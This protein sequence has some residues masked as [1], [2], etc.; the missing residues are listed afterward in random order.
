MIPILMYHAVSDDLTAS[1]R[2]YSSPVAEF[3]DQ[4]AYLDEHGY[5]SLTLADLC[6]RWSSGEAVPEK[7]VVITFDDGYECVHRTALPIL[8]RHGFVATTFVVSQY[9]GRIADFDLDRGAKARQ[10]LSIAQLRELLSAG[11]EIG[12]HSATHPTLTELARPDANAQVRDSRRQLEDLLGAPVTS[13]AYPKGRYNEAI[14]Q[15]VV[16]S[17][18]SAA[19]SCT[20][21]VNA[22][23]TDRLAL[24]RSG[25]CA[26]LSRRD[27]FWQLRLGGPPLQLAKTALGQWL[28]V[29]PRPDHSPSPVSP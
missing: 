14:R 26:S 17:G 5:Q 28:G 18:Y 6:G 8:Q 22:S 12:S 19:C 10:T 23:S 2:R 7:C 20:P 11:H 9:V 27:F 13:F 3:A 16:E 25:I 24:K 4:M 29:G 21:G 1:E 15:S